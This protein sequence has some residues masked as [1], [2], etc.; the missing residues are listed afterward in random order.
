M[1]KSKP[2]AWSPPKTS[3]L[4]RWVDKRTTRGD[5]GRYIKARRDNTTK[6]VH[7]S[8][9]QSPVKRGSASGR[10]AEHDYAHYDLAEANLEHCQLRKS[11][12]SSQLPFLLP[13]IDAEHLSRVKMTIF[14]SGRTTPMTTWTCCFGGRV[15]LP[16]ERARSVQRM[17]SID[18][19]AV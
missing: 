7:S 8:P 5:K 18:V 6:S 17:E 4:V 10:R 2:K 12:A 1:V 13:F 11:M 15:H 9:V 16:S 14:V 19:T 3:S